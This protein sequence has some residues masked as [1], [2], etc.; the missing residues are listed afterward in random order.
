M[1]LGSA[2]L[3]ASNLSALAETSTAEVAEACF[4]T[5]DAPEELCACVGERSVELNDKQR[6]C[7]VTALNKDDAETTRLRSSMPPTELIDVVTFMRTAP[8]DCVNPQ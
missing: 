8:V 1:L 5:L 7:Y 4:A 2:L 6:E 3:L